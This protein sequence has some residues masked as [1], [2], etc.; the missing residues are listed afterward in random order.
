MSGSAAVADTAGF[1]F[2]A[3]FKAL[4]R[5]SQ[6]AGFKAGRTISGSSRSVPRNRDVCESLDVTYL[7]GSS[8]GLIHTTLKPGKLRMK[9]AWPHLRTGGTHPNRRTVVR[10]AAVIL[11]AVF[12]DRPNARKSGPFR[13][14]P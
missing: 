3:P 10:A 2:S 5:S 12:P 8:L 14:R 13:L 4:E 9:E 11:G 6:D 7:D 1:F